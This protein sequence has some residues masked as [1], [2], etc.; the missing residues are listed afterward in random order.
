M[1]RFSLGLDLTECTLDCSIE[2]CDSSATS[3][4][5]SSPLINYKPQNSFEMDESLGI[6][7][8]DQMVEFLDSNATTANIE[9]A[10]KLAMLK[11]RVDQ[12]PSPE[13]LPLDPV[14]VK[15]F[16]DK[17]TT[18]EI[19]EAADAFVSE[20]EIL[21]SQLETEPK[22]SDSMIKS[23]AS[24]VSIS[25][26]TSVTSIASIDNGYQGDGEMSRPA[27][28]G[29]TQSGEPS[30][31]NNRRAS[32]ERRRKV[33]GDNV[34]IVR[35]QDPMTDS[36]FFTESDAE[37]VLHRG[38]R[39]VQI[40]DGHLYNGKGEVFINEQPQNDATSSSCMDSSGIYTD[41]EN[42]GDDE[43]RRNGDS[44]NSP[45]GSTDTIKSSDHTQNDKQQV[46]TDS[47][48]M[49]ELTATHQQ[50]LAP[51]RALQST[52]MSS[53]CE[54]NDVPRNEQ[55]SGDAMNAHA[56]ATTIQ[57]QPK[58]LKSSHYVSSVI[59][60]ASTSSAN[61]TTTCVKSSNSSTSVSTTCTEKSTTSTCIV[62]SKRS[63]PNRRHSKNVETPTKRINEMP[64]KQRDSTGVNSPGGVRK[65]TPN[66]WDKVMSTIARNKAAAEVNPK[67]YSEVKSKVTSGLGLKRQS[68]IASTA[69]SPRFSFVDQSSGSKTTTVSTTANASPLAGRQKTTGIVTKR[70]DN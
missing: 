2:F 49:N 11:Y 58:Q 31:L 12:T 53:S 60:D 7:T 69:S 35:R 25:F 52:A 33:D 50:K 22:T 5:D 64:A 51:V 55:K 38:D 66:K 68:P 44:D 39:R 6:L 19:S 4:Q 46:V 27:S 13:E 8:P 9:A 61:T 26:I 20:A 63:S 29:G 21:V 42:R 43:Q 3:A 17:T 47:H 18:E 59:S 56:T 54:D 1:K 15:T 32:N 23:T 36:D 10:H 37:D 67:K 28:R 24:K 30:A 45:N 65:I 70:L 40:I 57:A 62:K 34:Q 16:D 41:N 14:A 48:S